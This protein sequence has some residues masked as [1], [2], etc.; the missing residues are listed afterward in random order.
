M[1]G[2]SL[3]ISPGAAIVDAGSVE[4]VAPYSNT[5]AIDLDGTGDV[6][7]TYK[8][9]ALQTLMRSDFSISF[10]VK[11]SSWQTF[12]LMG[13]DTTT[14]AN[15][16]AVF[17]RSL[18]IGAVYWQTNIK[19]GGVA[20]SGLAAAGTP[21]TSDYVHFVVTLRKGGASTNGTFKLYVDGVEK[22][23]TSASTGTVQE[24]T[25]VGVP[26][27]MPFGAYQGSNGTYSGHATGTFDEIAT[28]TTQ[29]SAAEVTALYNSGETFDISSDSGDYTSSAFLQNWYRLNNDLTN[30][31]SLAT[32]ATTEGDPA[33][34]TTPTPP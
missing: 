21:S 13:F 12:Y 16:T 17:V 19:L 26:F 24:A 10:W 1:L 34:V 5:H 4:R 22:I 9:G 8:S 2:L 33:F 28:W 20:Y 15:T 6:I 23:S 27:N 14:G 11:V 32:V 7:K 30:S 25:L 3:N 31:G 18:N 29:L